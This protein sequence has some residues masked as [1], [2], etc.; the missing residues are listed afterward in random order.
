MLY[1]RLIKK[2]GPSKDP[3]TNIIQIPPFAATQETIKQI[4]LEDRW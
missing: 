4:S 2:L 3:E 1:D